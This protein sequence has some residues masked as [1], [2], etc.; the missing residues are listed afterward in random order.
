LRYFLLYLI[1]YT[2]QLA[3]CTYIR[4]IHGVITLSDRQIEECK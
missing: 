1:R 4:R 3:A 2:S